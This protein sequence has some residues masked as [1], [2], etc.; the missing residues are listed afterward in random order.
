[1]HF[2]SARPVPGSIL[3]SGVVVM[4]LNLDFLGLELVSASYK[5][6]FPKSFDP[7]PFISLPVTGG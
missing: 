7:S 4:N 6:T 3:Q 5:V 2:S 1:M